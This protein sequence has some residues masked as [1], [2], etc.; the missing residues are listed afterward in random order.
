M[1]G[2][3]PGNFGFGGVSPCSLMLRGSA[4]SHSA[5][6]SNLQDISTN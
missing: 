1:Y 3:Y 5:D 4:P 6:V 2:N